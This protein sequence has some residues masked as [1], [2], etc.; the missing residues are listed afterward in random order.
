[1][2]TRREKGKKERRGEKRR[3][4]KKTQN[5]KNPIFVQAMRPQKEIHVKQTV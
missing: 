4:E 1:M 5:P 3:G 2:K